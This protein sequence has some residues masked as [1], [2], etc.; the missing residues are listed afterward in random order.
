ME[1]GYKVV[2]LDNFITGD[3]GNISHLA[4]GKNFELVNQDISKPFDVSGRVDFVLDFASPA[5][6][7]DYLKHPVETLKVGSFGTYNMLEVARKKSAVFMQA[8]TSEVYGDPLVN[9]Q[10]ESYWGNVNP[11][12]PR[13]VYDE[14]KRFA[15]ALT[16]AYHRAYNLDTK[17][18]RIFNTFGPRMRLNDGRAVPNFIYQALNNKPLTIYG[19]GK[20]TRSFCYVSDL[21][22][23]IYL[24]LMSK[25]NEPVNLGNPGEVSM[26]ELADLITELTNSK[27]RRVFKQL[28]AD[29]PKVRCPDI[30]KARKILKWQ[31]KVKIEE[32]LKKTIDWFKKHPHIKK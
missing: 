12:G 17:I 27:S 23:G 1:K 7:V 10:N 5:S 19:N 3:Q 2:C 29:D 32:G 11:I 28:P 20:Q 25:E 16:M 9:P 30:S 15:E 24:L 18:V 31:P 21:V 14:S 6:P 13:S 4:A 26:L 8:S 22:E